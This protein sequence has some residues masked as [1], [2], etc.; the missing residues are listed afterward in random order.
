MKCNSEEGEDSFPVQTGAGSM[1]QLW[2]TV[3]KKYPCIRTNPF[4]TYGRVKYTVRFK[5]TRMHCKCKRILFKMSGI[6]RELKK[7][8]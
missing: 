7:S 1:V 6:K 5:K 8:V 4:F 3:N 2:L